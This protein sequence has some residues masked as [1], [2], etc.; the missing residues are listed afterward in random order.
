LFDLFDDAE[1]IALVF[2]DMNIDTG[3]SQG[4]LLPNI[5]AAF[6]EYESDVCSD[7]SSGRPLSGITT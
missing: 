4:R 1:G 6:T 3:T 7:Y 5:M 2:L